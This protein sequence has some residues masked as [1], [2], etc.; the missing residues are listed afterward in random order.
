MKELAWSSILSV[1]IDEIDEDH[2]RLVNLFNLLNHSIEAGDSEDY[3]ESVL[4]ELIACTAWHFKHEERLM[5][6]FNYDEFEQ[7]KDEHQKLMNSSAGL[8]QKFLSQ[9]KTLTSEDI[10]YIETWLTEHILT[11]DMKLGVFL[12]TVM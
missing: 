12:N 1:E 3:I 7:H 11:T 10:D 6:K 5:L 9:K 2:R 4:E 8:L